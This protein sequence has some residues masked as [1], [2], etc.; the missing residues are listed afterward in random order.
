MRRSLFQSMIAIAAAF[1]VLSCDTL[2]YDTPSSTTPPT[3]TTPSRPKGTIGLLNTKGFEGTYLISGPGDYH[4]QV[5]TKGNGGGDPYFYPP[6]AEGE[7]T[8]KFINLVSVD[9]V[10]QIDTKKPIFMGTAA[11]KIPYKEQE[12]L[13]PVTEISAQI[14][15]PKQEGI[16]IKRVLVTDIFDSIFIDGA[17]VKQSSTMSIELDSYDGGYIIAAK[18]KMFITFDVVNESGRPQK[19]VT[20]EVPLE[21]RPE[22]KY[23][24]TVKESGGKYVAFIS[25]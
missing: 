22:H 23:N 15:F 4:N 14:S 17:F 11:L 19:S 7:Y 9:N 21:A 8:V 13:V 24:V 20:L 3:P 6:R 5:T 2:D 12:I 1:V 18:V 16:Q 10:Y 25:E